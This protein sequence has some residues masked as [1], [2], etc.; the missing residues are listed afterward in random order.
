MVEKARL[1]GTLSDGE[2]DE[3]LRWVSSSDLVEEADQ[4]GNYG[5]GNAVSSTR[6]P[7]LKSESSTER[8]F[9]C[10]GRPYS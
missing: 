5:L 1:I 7:I 6:S 9:G 3:C 2:Y 4:S 10:S 8:P